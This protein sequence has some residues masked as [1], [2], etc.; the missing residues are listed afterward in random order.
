[1]KKIFE[2]KE[3]P[4][5][6]AERLVDSPYYKLRVGR[7]RVIMDIDKTTIRISIVKIGDRST[8]YS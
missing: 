8:V 5:R 2:L 6:F 7:F 4:F 3:D 1:L